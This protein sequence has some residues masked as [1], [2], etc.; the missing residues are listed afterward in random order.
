MSTAQSI[1]FAFLALSVLVLG[2]TTYHYKWKARR[3]RG[4]GAGWPIRTVKLADF[5]P[6]FAGG[7]L[8]PGR[9][10][11][12]RFIGEGDGVPGGAS[13]RESWI[14][15]ALATRAHQLFEFGTCT[16][17][18]TH[19]WA[20]NSPAG[21]RI[22]TLTLAPDHRADY[23]RAPG[24]S[25]LA[26]SYALA[27]SAFTAFYYTGTATAAKIEQLYG[28]SKA[29]DESPYAGRCDLI[30]IDG[31]HAY[32][33]VESDTA[34]ALRMVA[35]G[36]IILWHDYRGPSGE[37]R[38]VYRYLNRLAQDRPLVRIDRTS[39]IAYRA[40]GPAPSAS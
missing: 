20:V 34:K 8:G 18:T 9:E 5:D 39:L 25:T 26:E 3:A 17:K 1:A 11:E 38:D 35:P 21:A 7:P 31:S 24:D 30:F 4:S 14:L 32:S 2:W 12:V 19:L 40:P 13:D 27:E 29:F 6:L 33:Y 15:A 16:G 23:Q 37:T 10:T 28:D 36:G 22:H